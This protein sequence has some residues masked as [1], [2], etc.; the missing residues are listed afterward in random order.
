MKE[1]HPEMTRIWSA[2]AKPSPSQAVSRLQLV[3]KVYADH[4]E[5]HSSVQ[6]I[7]FELLDVTR[8]HILK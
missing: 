4:P 5:Y 8:E 3:E 2:H 6:V 1:T 7:L